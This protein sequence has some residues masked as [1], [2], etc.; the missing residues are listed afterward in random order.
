M[1]ANMGSLD[2]ALR[3]IIGLLLIV[4]PLVTTLGIHATAWGLWLSVILG[5]IPA[6]TAIYGV[7]PVY[8][9]LGVKTC[10]T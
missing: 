3:G 4:L 8:F 9:L 2:R 7:C 6:V 5:A 1:T 10:K